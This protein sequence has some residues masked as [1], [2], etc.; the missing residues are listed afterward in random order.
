MRCA[1]A[2]IIALILL[3]AACLP[4]GFSGSATPVPEHMQIPIPQGAI[5]NA[6]S[7]ECLQT[8]ATGDVAQDIETGLL[9]LNERG[10][11]ID[12]RKRTG[13]V[14]AFST[15][16]A[17]P[18]D[19]WDRPPERNA[20]NLAH[21]LVHYCQ[22]DAWGNETF[23]L[24]YASSLGRLQTEVPAFR[25]SLIS[26]RLQGKSCKFLQAKADGY[27]RMLR[28]K[29]WLMDLNEVDFNEVLELA[30]GPELAVVCDPAEG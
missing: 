17:V 13:F 29:Y 28:E 23:D 20:V 25:Q 5:D 15:R 1:R 10:V 18:R 8:W 4:L 12:V 7:T 30:W 21:E 26:W 19:Y 2:Y 6:T 16:P 9:K 27:A 24:S 11:R 22:R 14:R 3:L